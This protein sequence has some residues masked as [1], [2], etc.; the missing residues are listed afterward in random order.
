M[1]NEDPP[2]E[3]V[4]TAAKKEHN[5]RGVWMKRAGKV[6]KDKQV[7]QYDQ[8]GASVRDTNV[9][10]PWSADS[11]SASR[12]PLHIGLSYKY[13]AAATQDCTTWDNTK[14]RETQSEPVVLARD[15]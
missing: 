7:L 5:R 15:G 3:T 14:R 6:A 4:I 2:T 13:Q 1:R 12:A 11:E 8:N 9:A 10:H